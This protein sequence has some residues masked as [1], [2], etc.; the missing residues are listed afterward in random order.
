VHWWIEDETLWRGYFPVLDRTVGTERIETAVL[1]E[2][3]GFEVRFLPSLA[4]LEIN[5]DDAIDRKNWEDSWVEDVS[6]PNQGLPPPAAVEVTMEVSGL[7]AVK[8]LYVL[9]EH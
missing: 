5:R 4:M 1:N 6:Q 7:G 9:P 3:E 8:R 2:V